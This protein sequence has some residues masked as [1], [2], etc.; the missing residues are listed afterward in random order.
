MHAPPADEIKPGS[1][2]RPGAI[3]SILSCMNPLPPRSLSSVP[4]WLVLLQGVL[5]LLIGIL[6]FMKPGVTMLVLV[7]LLGFYW[8]IK[9]IFSLTAI[10]H[11]ES[12]SHRGWLIFNSLLGIVAG[13]SVLDHPLISSV[14]VPAVLV[15]FIGVAGLLIGFNDLFAAFRGAG[16]S[17]GLLGA[18][19]VLLG[20]ALLFN[21]VIGVALLPYFIGGVELTG[22]ALAS[23][24]AFKLRASQVR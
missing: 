4:W 21:T 9:G 5:S 1:T 3:H 22:G 8:L 24:I 15:T 11:P 14:F 19:S 12:R 2:R 16:W 6:L 13:F 10:F 20:G 7:R 18:V 17:L 23:A